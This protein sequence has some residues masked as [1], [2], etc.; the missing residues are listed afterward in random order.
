MNKAFWIVLG[1]TVV[2]AIGYLLVLRA[3]D[4]EPPYLKLAGVLALLGV[5]FW[6]IGKTKA[7][8]VR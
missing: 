6:W 2:V 7:K 8:T 3:M 1:P 5:G 4:L